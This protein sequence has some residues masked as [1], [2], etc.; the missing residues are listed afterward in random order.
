[1]S[2]SETGSSKLEVCQKISQASKETVETMG[3]E[4]FPILKKNLCL[5][6]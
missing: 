4:K 3:L 6:F 5:D 1:V 2:R